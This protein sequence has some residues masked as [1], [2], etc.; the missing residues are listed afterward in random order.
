MR[1]IHNYGLVRIIS[2]GDPFHNT[3]NIQVQIKTGDAWELYHGFNSLSDDYAYAN[4]M[5]AASRAIA[6]VAKEKA[7]TLIFEHFGY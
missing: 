1:I 7:S 6:K 5:E 4:A 2:L 3:Y